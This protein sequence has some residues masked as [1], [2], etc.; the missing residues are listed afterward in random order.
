MSEAG[1][2]TDKYEAASRLIATALSVKTRLPQRPIEATKKKYA[3]IAIDSFL[4]F[5]DILD[6]VVSVFQLNCSYSLI[7]LLP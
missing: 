2:Y 6:Q 5:N 3:S 1:D 4:S 7:I